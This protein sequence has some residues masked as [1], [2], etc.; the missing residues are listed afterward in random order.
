[1]LDA[2]FDQRL[3]HHAGQ[4]QVEGVGV[5]EFFN[6]QLFS[7]THDLDVEIVVGEAEFLAQGDEGLAVAQQYAQDVGELDDH[8]A[9]EFRLKAHQRGDGVQRV[10]QKVGMDLPLQ[11]LH[12]GFE[13]ELGLLF[14]LL[15]EAER[16]PYLQRDTNHHRRSGVDGKRDEP[17]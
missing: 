12:A 11:C 8:L 1:M 10:E 6:A 2:V 4:Q 17:A 5:D 14:K 15:F 13:Q 3:Q 7:K 9:G 16:V